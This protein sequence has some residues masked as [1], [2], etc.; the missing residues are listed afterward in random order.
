MP[1]EATNWQKIYNAIG[2]K[3]EVKTW[4]LAWQGLTDTKHQIIQ[5]DCLSLIGNNTVI[6]ENVNYLAS[7]FHCRSQSAKLAGKIYRIRSK[8]L[9]KY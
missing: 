8:L 5:W 9:I 1:A 3:L 6:S 7:G 2:V 4:L